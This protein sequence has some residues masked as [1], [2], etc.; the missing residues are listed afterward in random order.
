MAWKSNEKHES[1]AC[2]SLAEHREPSTHVSCASHALL[3]PCSSQLC[4]STAY[5]SSWIYLRFTVDELICTLDNVSA[6]SGCCGHMT[7]LALENLFYLLS[8]IF[9]LKSY[10]NFKTHL[11]CHFFCENCPS[12]HQFHVVH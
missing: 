10:L 2:G 8:S 6:L 3:L 1:K 12:L 9:M 5:T 7:F 4:R 11:N